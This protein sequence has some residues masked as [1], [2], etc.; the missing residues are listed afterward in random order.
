MSLKVFYF[1][2][3]STFLFQAHKAY[4]SP[5]CFIQEHLQFVFIQIPP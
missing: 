5:V 4:L 3:F 2:Y 1:F